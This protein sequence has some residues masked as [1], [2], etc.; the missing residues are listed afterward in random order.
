MVRDKTEAKQTF[1]TKC[2]VFG[3]FDAGWS[4]SSIGGEIISKRFFASIVRARMDSKLW[5]GLLITE[6]K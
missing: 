5:E 4:Y 2:F 3:L 1:R 6:G